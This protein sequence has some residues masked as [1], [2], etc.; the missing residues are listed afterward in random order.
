MRAAT[1]LLLVSCLAGCRSVDVG[2]VYDDEFDRELSQTFNRARPEN[3]A[4]ARLEFKG[5]H[6]Q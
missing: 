1:P 6:L 5:N 4:G 2:S 3:D